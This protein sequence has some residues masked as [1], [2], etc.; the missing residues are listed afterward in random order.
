MHRVVNIGRLVGLALAGLHQGAWAVLVALSAQV[1]ILGQLLSN[2]QLFNAV[3]WM[4]VSHAVSGHSHHCF[5]VSKVSHSAHC[6]S[7]HQNVA[8][9][10]Q[11]EGF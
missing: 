3:D 2:H 1:R 6:V 4:N 8:I 11:F 5:D 10:Q 7:L 9:G